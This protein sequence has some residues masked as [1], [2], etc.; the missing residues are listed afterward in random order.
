[1]ETWYAELSYFSDRS[2]VWILEDILCVEVSTL[3]GIPINNF[4]VI[5]EEW[6]C[7]D[8]IFF[9]QRG[10]MLALADVSTL[11]DIRTLLGTRDDDPQ[12]PG[13]ETLGKL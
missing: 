5:A 10:K 2:L 1:M 11:K 13:N 9:S 3:S 8:I 7:S 4:L 12:F 6:L